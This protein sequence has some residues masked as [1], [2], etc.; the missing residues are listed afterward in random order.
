MSSEFSAKQNNSCASIGSSGLRG[1]GVEVADSRIDCSKGEAISMVIGRSG[2]SSKE[3]SLRGGRGGVRESIASVS[4][5]R[6]GESPRFN[7]GNG[8]GSSWL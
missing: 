5:N 4:R 7:S 6:N 8:R 1:N 2:E 3:S